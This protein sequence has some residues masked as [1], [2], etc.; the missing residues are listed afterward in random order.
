MEKNSS[1]DS[2]LE[3]EFIPA[4]VI[5]QGSQIPLSALHSDAV[6]IVQSVKINPFRHAAVFQH[7]DL[8]I[9]TGLTKEF[10]HNLRT[11]I[12][13]FIVLNCQPKGMRGVI[14]REELKSAQ[15]VFF[16]P[17]NCYHYMLKPC[18]FPW[19]Q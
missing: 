18:W 3:L 14:I 1:L 10:P 7:K 13:V 17:F 6:V 2:S 15:G 9:Q 4:L 16:F 5:L 12:G 11:S 19:L 8:E